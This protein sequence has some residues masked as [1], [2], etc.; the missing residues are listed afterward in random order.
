MQHLPNIDA[1]QLLVERIWPE[2][3]KKLPNQELHIYGSDFPEELYKI[4]AQLK[5]EG[6]RLMGRLESLEEIGKYIGM[7][8]PLR[9]GAGIKGK[10]VDSWFYH[11]P[12]ITT[13]IGSEGLF[14]ESSDESASY[15]QVTYYNEK[16]KL[17]E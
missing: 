14:L 5:S 11:T 7:L 1:T 13:P 3:R 2:V 9:F 16:V 4:S 6:I 15:S 17:T 8:A 12:A 10:I